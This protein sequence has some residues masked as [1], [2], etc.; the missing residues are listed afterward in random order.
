MYRVQ[1]KIMIDK[2][3]YQ[4]IEGTE[5]IKKS[6]EGIEIEVEINSYMGS[7]TL[8]LSLTIETSNFSMA[9]INPIIPS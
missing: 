7:I 2:G 4:T 6:N 8:C 3:I 5:P 9:C 1:G